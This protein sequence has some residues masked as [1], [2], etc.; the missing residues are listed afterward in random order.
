LANEEIDHWQKT[1][2]KAVSTRQMVT[3]YRATLC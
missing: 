3:F 1:G 2:T